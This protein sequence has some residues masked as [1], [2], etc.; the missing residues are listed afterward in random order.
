M[1]IL[2]DANEE[3]MKK[4]KEIILLERAKIEIET[5]KRLGIVIRFGM[6]PEEIRRL[7]A[8]AEAKESATR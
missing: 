7:I 1:K 4:P 6:S 5:A 3:S 2:I 8:G